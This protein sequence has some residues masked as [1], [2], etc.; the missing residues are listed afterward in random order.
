MIRFQRADNCFLQLATFFSINCNVVLFFSWLSIECRPTVV[1]DRVRVA[2]LTWLVHAEL[3]ALLVATELTVRSRLLR[4]LTLLVL[5]TR[6][7]HLAAALQTAQVEL[8]QRGQN[9]NSN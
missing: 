7:G 8:L 4:D 5:R 3:D 9:K 1:L 2:P 6:E